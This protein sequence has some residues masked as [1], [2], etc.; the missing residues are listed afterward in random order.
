MDRR[1]F[2]TTTAAASAAAAATWPP[3]R[4]RRRARRTCW[5]WPTSSAPTRW[6]STPWA[7]TG[8]ATASAGSCYD[9]LMTYGKKTL[10]DGRVMYDINKLE[11]E[12]AESW[13]IAPDGESVTFKLRKNAKFHDG[14]PVTAK[15]VKWSFDRAVTRGRL[16]HLPDGRRLAGKARAVR[17]GR[18]AHLP[19]KFLRRDKLTMNDLAVRRALRLQQRTGEEE[20]HR[21]TTPGAWPG[22]ATTPPAAA[23]TRSRPSAPARKSSTCATTTGRAARCRSCAA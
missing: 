2:L 3:P 19:V 20:R 23:P 5:W 21:R 11:P 16:P 7:P 14:T 18:R 6:T 4:R 13:K 22:R 15:D 9:R 12:L 17:G 1:D 10:P 8:R